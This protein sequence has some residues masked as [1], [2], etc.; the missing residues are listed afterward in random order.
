MED[1]LSVYQRPY[2]PSRPV[3]CIDERSKPLHATPRGSLPADARGA[4]REDYEYQRE[5]TCNAFLA[6]E[7]LAGIRRVRVT[8]QRTYLDFADLLRELVDAWYPEAER[9]VLV[10]DNL[11]VHS[12]AAL[13]ERFLP[14]EA[15]RIAS[16]LEWHYT[17]EHGSWLNVAEC[18]LSVFSRQCLNR[19]LGSLP[20]VSQEAATWES[21][22]NGAKALVRWHFTTKDAR[23]KLRRLYPE[24]REQD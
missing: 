9:I 21:R 5:G 16:K 12:V 3:V 11:N 2:D 20:E 1:V 10:T 4:V 22:R 17:P 7:P 6:I 15:W 14:A 19:R 13:Y 23:I 18:E 8:Q 24:I